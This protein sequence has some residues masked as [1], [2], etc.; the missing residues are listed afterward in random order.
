MGLTLW[1]DFERIFRWRDWSILDDVM[2][3]LIGAPISD[4]PDQM[5]HHQMLACSYVIADL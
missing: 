3:Q 2:E 5:P 1:T 4:R